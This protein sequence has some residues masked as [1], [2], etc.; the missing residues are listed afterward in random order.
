MSQSKDPR[1][2]RVQVCVNSGVFKNGSEMLCFAPRPPCAP[3]KK[4][5]A[6][7]HRRKADRRGSGDAR[8]SDVWRGAESVTA[9]AT[10]SGES[11]LHSTVVSTAPC[12]RCLLEMP[13]A[14]PGL[15]ELQRLCDDSSAAPLLLLL[16]CSAHPRCNE[17]ARVEALYSLETAAL[18]YSSGSLRF[19][20]TDGADF[21]L[22]ALNLRGAD[23]PAMVLFNAPSTH[24]CS[25]AA[26]AVAGG[27]RPEAV[28][29]F[30]DAAR[31]GAAPPFVRS[32]E[33]PPL[34]LS[35]RTLQTASAASLV[36]ARTSMRQI[37]LLLHEP[38]GRPA[39]ALSTAALS[40]FPTLTRPCPSPHTC[41]LI[42]TRAEPCSEPELAP[43]P[44][45]GSKA[46]RLRLPAYHGRATRRTGAGSPPR[47]R[48]TRRARRPTRTG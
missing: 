26:V 25:Q 18:N 28:Q 8:G 35:E 36:E 43:A 46:R 2:R 13:I 9:G 3:G 6:V 47:S 34:S 23:L 29:H 42:R 11:D 44:Q 16:T 40:S 24:V 39:A 21:P 27:W 22:S 12:W 1:V 30:V 38:R 48:C 19:A 37:V 41:A 15:A 10:R 31:K 32:E 33:A 14:Q 20:R 7:R 17:A 5:K 45:P 4:Y